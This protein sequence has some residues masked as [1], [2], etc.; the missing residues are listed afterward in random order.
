[1]PES[2]VPKRGDTNSSS[3]RG[4]MIELD[5]P[6]TTNNMTQS[7][8]SNCI[9]LYGA[10]WLLLGCGATLYTSGKIKL[11]LKKFKHFY[12]MQTEIL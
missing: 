4:N 1:M 11:L 9:C 2:R 6:E 5:K 7:N 10:A 3:T 8:T 12:F